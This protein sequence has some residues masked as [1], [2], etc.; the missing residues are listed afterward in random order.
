MNQEQCYVKRQPLLLP[1]LE[2]IDGKNKQK[3][4]QQQQEQQK[5]G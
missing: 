5:K 3:K 4:R 2:N 1:L